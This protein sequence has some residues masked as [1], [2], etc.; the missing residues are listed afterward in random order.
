[1]DAEDWGRFLSKV[2]DDWYARDYGKVHVDLFENAVAQSLG[3]PSQRCV[4]AE[5]CGK[6][7]AIEH[8]GDVFSCDHYVYPEY[9]LGNISQTHWGDMA[10]A[11]RQ[12]AFGFAKRDTLPSDCRECP[13]LKLCWGECPKNR[14]LRTTSGELG[15]NYLCSGLKQF[16]AHIQRD[17][18]R[19]LRDV[20]QRLGRT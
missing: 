16:Y 6:G 17:I 19:I 14:L 3:M 2:W 18:P 11:Q 1:M 7:L 12:Q 9:K 8:N 20:A 4:T 15:L 13:H 5:F 10:Y